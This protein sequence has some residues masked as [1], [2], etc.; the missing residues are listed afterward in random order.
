V[1]KCSD[2]LEGR[3]YKYYST[4]VSFSKEKWST[5]KFFKGIFNYYFPPDFHLKQQEHL[6]HFNQK[7]HCIQE[8]ATELKIIYQT[9]GHSTKRE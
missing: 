2:F 7:D 1:A 6:E 9:L 4:E 8:Y 3:T 5:E